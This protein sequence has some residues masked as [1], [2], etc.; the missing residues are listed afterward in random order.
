VECSNKNHPVDFQ[1]KE[2]EM[3][4]FQIAF[5]ILLLPVAALAQSGKSPQFIN[6]PES[7]KPPG[8]T[9]AVVISGNKLVYLSGQVALNAHGDLVGKDD[10]RAQ[11]TQAFENI[12]LALRAAG[13]TAA[14]LVKLNYFVVGLDPDKLKIIR[15]VRDQ[16]VNTAE[17]PASTL[18]GVVHLFREGF[19]IEVEGVAV[20][21]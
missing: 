2:T 9:H 10:F 12:K 18:V 19:E 11:V 8:Y 14:H 3:N 7:P 4:Q 1:L 20:I 17:P 6:P 13:T 21:P 16:Y 15:E 5:G